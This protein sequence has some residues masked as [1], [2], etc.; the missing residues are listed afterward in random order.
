MNEKNISQ[1]YRLKDI[2]ETRNYFPEKIDQ[3]ELISKKQK[4]FVQL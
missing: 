2:N 1:E 4:K 3:S